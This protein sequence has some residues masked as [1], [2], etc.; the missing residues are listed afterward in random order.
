MP[1]ASGPAPTPERSRQS[2]TAELR[3]LLE[4][5]D[6]AAT[7]WWQQHATELRGQLNPELHLC[8]NKAIRDYDFETALQWLDRA[9]EAH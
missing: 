4:Q 1:P 5:G 2:L 3:H 8:L 9:L 7:E 6:S